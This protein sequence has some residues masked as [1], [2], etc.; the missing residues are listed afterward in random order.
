MANHAGTDQGVPDDHVNDGDA[1]AAAQILG[2]SAASGNAADAATSAGKNAPLNL[3]PIIPII[4]GVSICA[5][6]ILVTARLW[7]TAYRSNYG[8]VN[9]V[10]LPTTI[11]L[12]LISI[13][14]FVGLFLIGYAILLRR[15]E[16][17]QHEGKTPDGSRQT[18]TYIKWIVVPLL[19][20]LLAPILTVWGAQ[21]IEPI[22][23]KP[24]ITLYQE[25]Q[26][27]KNDNPDFRMYG[28]DRDQLRCSINQSVLTK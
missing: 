5:L 13:S 26:N 23:P 3:L 22:A 20:A 9:R 28:Y 1:K 17:D 2:D 12:A 10:N 8:W 27:I 25:A 4:L 11:F 16:Q 15:S 18:L 19:V 21:M 7:K 6:N 14:F 24:C